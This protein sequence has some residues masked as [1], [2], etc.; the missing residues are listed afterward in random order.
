MGFESR[1]ASRSVVT[2][3]MPARAQRRQVARRQAAVH[4]VYRVGDQQHMQSLG[5]RL[6]A[7]Q[8]RVAQLDATVHGAACCR[9]ARRA[10][11]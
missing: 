7:G 5:Y 10:G 3:S 8:Q 11:C 4:I 1:S 2:T 6:L 9:A